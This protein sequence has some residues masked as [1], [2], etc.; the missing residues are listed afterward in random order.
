MCGVCERQLNWI[1][2]TLLKLYN[3]TYHIRGL[4]NMAL[5]WQTTFSRQHGA[6]LANNLFQTTWRSLG[7]QTFPVICWN[8]KIT[9]FWLK[10]HQSLFPKGKLTHW[11]QEKMAAILQTIFWNA[12]CFMG[13][14][15]FWWKFHWRFISRVLST[16]SQHLCSQWLGIKLITSHYLNQW[17]PILLMH[18]CITRPQWVKNMPPLVHVKAWHLFSNKP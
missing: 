3:L 13:I 1:P 7:K 16:I 10:S 18:I 6:H 14:V 4:Y 5:T 9:V 12:Y 17:W 2:P 15:I 8:K 11:G